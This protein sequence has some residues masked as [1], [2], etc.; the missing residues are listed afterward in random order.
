[1]QRGMRDQMNKWVWIGYGMMWLSVALAVS[2]GIYF[3][4]SIHCLWFLLIPS[5]MSFRENKE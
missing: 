1:M 2:V 3:T 4:H 5:C